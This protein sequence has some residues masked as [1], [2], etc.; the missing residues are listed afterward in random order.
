MRFTGLRDGRR[1]QVGLLLD[2]TEGDGPMVVPLAEVDEFYAD[3]PGWTARARQITTGGHAL[4]DVVQAP[5]VPPGARVL[6]MGLNY[7]AHAAETG[8][9]LPRKPPLFGRWTASL[10]VDGT[11]VPVPPGER[12]LD[13]EG[14][15]AA[16]VGT[17]LTDVDEATA[18]AGVFGY[19]VFNDLSARRAQGA[20]AQ[21]TL[22]KNADRSGPMGPVVTADEVG[23]P[24]AGLRLVTRVNNEIVQ[25]GNTS[26]MIFSI[27]QI[28]SFV[29]RTLT[30]HPGDVL[31]T[32][33]PAGVGYTRTPPRYLTPGDVV[34]V[35]I[36]KVGYLR[37]PIVESS[38][39]P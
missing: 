11:P 36:D 12:G 14:E 15:L 28:L 34:T 20:S 32:G 24:A 25:D 2:P 3:L 23:D 21:W 39:R 27:G 16:V 6:G 1:V 35:S 33:T 8:Q 7:H 30:L 5:P 4:A 17:R 37:N 22:G 31:I 10:S 13:W 26:D 29:S 38:V 19:A 9:A 18:A